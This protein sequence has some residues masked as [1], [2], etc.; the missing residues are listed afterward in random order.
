M[1]AKSESVGWKSDDGGIGITGF[2]H[3]VVL[4]PWEEGV[5]TLHRVVLFGNDDEPLPPM[6]MYP[7]TAAALV[8]A[9]S[10]VPT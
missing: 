3:S 7:D 2:E 5:A 1:S 4:M 10:A 9:L 6:F 8:A